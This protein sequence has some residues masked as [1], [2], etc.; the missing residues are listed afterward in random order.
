MYAPPQQPCKKV[1]FSGRSEASL[2]LSASSPAKYNYGDP[3]LR[4]V[5]RHVIP[6]KAGIHFAEMDPRLRGDDDGYDFHFYASVETWEESV[7]NILC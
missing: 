3:L 4:S 6:A 1:T 2:Q 7:G 5:E